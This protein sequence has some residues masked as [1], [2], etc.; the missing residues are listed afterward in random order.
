MA[1]FLTDSFDDKQSK[2]S[3]LEE[4]NW[5]PSTFSRFI[6]V[7]GNSSIEVINNRLLF[8]M[9]NPFGPAVATVEYE[10]KTVDDFMNLSR[11]SAIRVRYIIRPG[12]DALLFGRMILTDNTDKIAESDIVLPGLLNVEN[13]RAWILNQ[14]VKDI[15][16]DFANIKKATVQFIVGATFFSNA[17]IF[18]LQSVIGNNTFNILNTCGY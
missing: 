14:F 5:T 11:I 10:K 7:S 8:D 4:G 9:N 6:D 13:E 15:G 17:T 12:S 16:F 1:L 3:K 18:S 2:G